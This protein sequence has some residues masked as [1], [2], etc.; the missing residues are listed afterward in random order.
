MNW[1]PRAAVL[2][3]GCGTAALAACSDGTPAFCEPLQETADLAALTSALE[4]GDLDKAAS[5]ARRLADLAEEAP[6]EIRA[7]FE[8]LTQG[9]VDIVDLV[10]EDRAATAVDPGATSSTV[11]PSEVERRRDELN[12]RLSDLDRRSDRISAWAVEQCGLDL[13]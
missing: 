7:D 4:A 3:L 6:A 8:A 10:A 13:S 5:E 11:D 1:R 12:E 2:L 9:V